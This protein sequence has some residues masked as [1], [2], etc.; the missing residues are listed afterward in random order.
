MPNSNELHLL[1]DDDRR[2][3]LL[4]VE[5][6]FSRSRPQHV[7]L[8]ELAR[9]FARAHEEY[10]ELSMWVYM[11]E[12][13]L[14]SGQGSLE[15]C[16]LASRALML[17]AETSDEVDWKNWPEVL[18]A[19]LLE[20]DTQH[21]F[22]EIFPCGR[23]EGGTSP[24][25]SGILVEGEIY[26]IHHLFKVSEH[27]CSWVVRRYRRSSR[28][29][30]PS[31]DRSEHGHSDNIKQSDRKESDGQATGPYFANKNQIQQAMAERGLRYA[32]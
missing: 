16:E 3:L 11:N 15:F 30:S 25:H 12:V 2:R 31:A 5:Q 1:P 22:F 14:P 13:P 17:I 28:G 24:E 20:N 21:E 7:R 9:S 26:R 4:K 10:P 27:C 32:S 6:L 23:M 19:Y 18:L 8:E 29:P